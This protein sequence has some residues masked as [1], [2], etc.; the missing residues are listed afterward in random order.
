MVG[1]Y[2][3]TYKP[4]ISFLIIFAGAGR[5]DGSSAAPVEGGIDTLSTP[6]ETQELA[7]PK[8]DTLLPADC[9]RT[10]DTT[11]GATHAMDGELNVLSFA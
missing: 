5:G 7:S 3:R 11:Y 4:P 10:R 1:I 2:H 6:L 8:R 9:R